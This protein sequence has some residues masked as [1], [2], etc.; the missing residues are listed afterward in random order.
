M[1]LHNRVS[2]DQ[3]NISQ[4]TPPIERAGFI[5]TERES[6][7]RLGCNTDTAKIFPL[8]GNYLRP[9]RLFKRRPRGFG[10]QAGGSALLRH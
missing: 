7:R 3:D 9:R 1:L 2:F 5:R 10:P 4:G 8:I 6:S